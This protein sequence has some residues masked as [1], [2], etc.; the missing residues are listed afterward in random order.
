[1][2]KRISKFSPKFYENTTLITLFLGSNFPRQ[3]ILNKNLPFLREKIMKFFCCLLH[4][5]SSCPK[6][7]LTEINNKKL[8]EIQYLN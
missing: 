1:M 2:K 5:K 8:L 3:K 6:T 4:A 7:N